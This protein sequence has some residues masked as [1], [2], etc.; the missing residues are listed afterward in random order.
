MPGV[1]RVRGNAGSDGRAGGLDMKST[2][3]SGAVLK[4][5]IGLGALA[6]VAAISLLCSC[7]QHTTPKEEVEYVT[8][9]FIQAPDEYR[10]LAPTIYLDL[11]A[12]YKFRGSTLAS[13]NI[14]DFRE[15]LSTDGLEIPNHLEEIESYGMGGFT[16][17]D[18]DVAMSITVY[19]RN[20][21]RKD[22]MS[23]AEAQSL[24]RKIATP[25]ERLIHPV[26]NGLAVNFEGY[27]GK[28]T[29]TRMDKEQGNKLTDILEQMGE[30]GDAGISFDCCTGMPVEE[31][32]LAVNSEHYFILI[33]AEIYGE[34]N[35]KPEMMDVLV[36]IA[37][38]I[39]IKE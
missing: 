6:A 18:H 33:E 10:D 14:A 34:G 28:V 25:E 39:K 2:M 21:F 36:R 26:V 37:K 12:G 38:S 27:S 3:V 11:P 15:H 30:Q 13:G 19:S 5:R 1:G 29:Y 9:E 17:P 20:V 22:V 24:Y 7:A 4:R 16:G 23:E 35:S 31:V 8:I 32:A